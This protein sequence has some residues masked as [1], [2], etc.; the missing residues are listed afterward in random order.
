MILC[1]LL[2]I[3]LAFSAVFISAESFSEELRC[4]YCESVNTDAC[5]DPVDT[6]IITSAVCNTLSYAPRLHRDDDGFQV[7]D[8]ALEGIDGKF[9][10]V[11]LL[12]RI[13]DK[14]ETDTK[15]G[16]RYVCI[17]VKLTK[18]ELTSSVRTCERVERG[19]E[20]VCD[21]IAQQAD[22]RVTVRSCSSCESDN[23]NSSGSL[24]VN[25]IVSFVC[26]GIVSIL[27]TVADLS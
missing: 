17:K 8:T 10:G 15:D 22:P 4:Y 1:R 23:C 18:D 9:R 21:F 14:S 20:D 7:P 12:N 13:F 26:V 25:L 24:Q 2:I 11:Q 27:R 16:F 5:Q 19:V 3:S 6:S